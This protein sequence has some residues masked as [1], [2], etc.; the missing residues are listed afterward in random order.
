[1][2]W[3]SILFTIN[4]LMT[5]ALFVMV[6]YTGVEIERI[7]KD[8]DAKRRRDAGHTDVGGC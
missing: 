2:I 6:T 1:M 7:R 4:I 3:F 5:F 8:L